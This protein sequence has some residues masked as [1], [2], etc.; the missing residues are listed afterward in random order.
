MRRPEWRDF[1]GFSV[2][3][4]GQARQHGRMRLCL[5]F[6]LL[7]VAPLRA[8]W[9]VESS[10]PVPIAPKVP[11]PGRARAVTH[12]TITARDSSA[13]E[14]R[15]LELHFVTFNRNAAT[16]RVIDLPSGATVEEGIRAAG[17]LAGVNGG[18]F[19]PDRT[20]LGLVVSRGVKLHPFERT[21]LLTGLLAV[22]P[23]GANLLR[24]AEFRSGPNLKEALQAGPFLVDK[25]KTVAG[26]NATRAAERTV[27]LA[28]KS[29]V[30]A[31]LITGPVTLASLGQLLAT[32]GIFP[33]LKVE[34][35]LNLDGGSSTAL[36]VAGDPKPFSHPEWKRVRNAVAV[37]PKG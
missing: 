28:D 22:T 23:R 31:L 9:R 11:I 35:A 5:L 4:P 25:G 33:G 29:G 16:L 24:T 8:E 2:A 12:W 34:R 7:A 3:T 13:P 32:P 15:A 10:A 19:T 27:L 30:A 1:P 14:K 18:Y 37:V 36:W 26:L 21:K 6:F 20:P 17:G